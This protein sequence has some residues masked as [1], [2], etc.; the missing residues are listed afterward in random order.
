M[1]TKGNFSSGVAWA[2]LQSWAARG[3]TTFSFLIAGYFI[4]PAEFGLYALVASL[5]ALSEMLCEQALSQ[6]IV[7]TQM[8]DNN[9]LSTVFWISLTCGILFSMGFFVIGHFMQSLFDSSELPDLL[10]F[11][12][13][14]PIVIGTTAV[15]IGLLR[16]DLSFKALTK[17]TIFASGASSIV[18]VSLVFMGFGATGLVIQSIVYYLLGAVILWKHCEWRPSFLVRSHTA[19]TVLNLGI[20]NASGKILDFTETRGIEIAVGAFAGVHAMGAYAFANK[21]AQTAFQTLV[22]PV[23]EVTFAGIARGQEH[24][25]ASLK[26]GQL[27]I[28]TIPIAGLF[29]LAISAGPLLSL[30]Y[31][32]RWDAA[33]IPLT[34]LTLAYAFRSY[35]YCFGVAL[36]ASGHYKKSLK[37]SFMRVVICSAFA[38]VFLTV[39]NLSDFVAFSYLASAAII[40]PFFYTSGVNRPEHTHKADNCN[41]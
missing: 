5:L 16:R 21:V 34:L 28:A 3:I 2:Y 12:S 39:S 27:I 33:V 22:S 32:D 30:V 10:I 14:C 20:A 19:K 7:Q 1:S 13:I 35:L 4:S 23:L 31:G 37:L 6:G 38:A 24:F 15:P 9:E 17:R 41:P 25:L 26:S 36:Q 8:K 18:G 40:L 29:F 11:A